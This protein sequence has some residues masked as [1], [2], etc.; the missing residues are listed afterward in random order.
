MFPFMSPPAPLNLPGLPDPEAHPALRLA[1][2]V[3]M[4]VECI[5]LALGVE[6]QGK[7]RSLFAR[8]WPGQHAFM[9]ALRD[10]ARDFAALMEQLAAAPPSS[11]AAP[12]PAAPSRV[13]PT[14]RPGGTRTPS[15]RALRAARTPATRT[16]DAGTSEVS[17]SAAGVPATRPCLIHP[18]VP[19][20]A[21]RPGAAV[22]PWPPRPIPHRHRWRS[23]PERVADARL[24]CFDI[25][26]YAQP[27]AAPRFPP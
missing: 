19:C 25:V 8:L 27:P 26:S 4:L 10:S 16:P 14:R 21:P 23:P 17:T 7:L 5:G 12:S 15:P 1:Q 11:P 9:E 22:H 6:R 20:A 24:F 3:W 13:T 2:L 18:S